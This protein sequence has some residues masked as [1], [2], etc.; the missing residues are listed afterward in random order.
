MPPQAH[1]LSGRFALITGASRGIGRAVAVRFAAEGATV[2][3]NHVGDAAAAQ[4]TIALAAQAAAAAKLPAAPHCAVEADVSD[5]AQV[6]AMVAEVLQRWGRLD[7]LVNNAGIQTETPGGSF[8]TAALRK[9]LGVDLDGP[10]FCS[11]AA[12]AH[13]LSRPGGGTI[14]N[15]TSV[16]E[17]VPKPAYLAYSMAKGALGNLTRTLALEYA[18]RGIRVNAVGPGAVKTDMNA[19]WVADPVAKAGVESHIPMGFAADADEIAPVF[20]FLASEDAR[21]ITG[22]TIYA[23]GGI[24]LYGDFKQNW[25]S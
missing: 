14:I 3:V 13:F 25:A 9:V 10:A 12:I 23:C 7:I 22:Q 15:T 19:S 21:Y 4:E 11:R 5:E 1:R 18:D 6:D 24:T 16:H 2:A 17:I 20:A 8:D